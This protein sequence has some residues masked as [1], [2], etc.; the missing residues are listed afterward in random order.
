MADSDV[1][2]NLFSTQYPERRPL[3]PVRTEYAEIGL[4][5]GGNFGGKKAD[6]S[7]RCQRLLLNPCAEQ[8]AFEVLMKIV[9]L[10]RGNGSDL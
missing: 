10:G 6:R 2:S 3:R 4:P 9:R 7:K 5:T 8:E 1:R